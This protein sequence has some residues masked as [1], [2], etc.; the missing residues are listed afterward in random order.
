MIAAA[1]PSKMRDLPGSVA[2]PAWK[3]C[4]E[5]IAEAFIDEIWAEAR[6]TVAARHGVDDL[7]K[8]V[9]GMTLM[10][11]LSLMAE[12]VATRKALNF[13]SPYVKPDSHAGWF[14]EFGVDIAAE[15]KRIETEL[16]EAADAKAG[17]KLIK[18][19]NGKKDG[20]QKDN[21]PKQVAAFARTRGGERHPWL[22]FKCLS[23]RKFPMTS[24]L[25]VT[26]RAVSNSALGSST[27]AGHRSKSTWITQPP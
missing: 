8:V 25:P 5:A 14:K 26:T 19:I 27:L 18:E 4:I 3:R 2:G 17:K 10:E 15:R 16:K 21:S 20:R 23:L 13:R 12:L 11:Q 7:D 6:K 22:S 24:Q 9:H 1:V